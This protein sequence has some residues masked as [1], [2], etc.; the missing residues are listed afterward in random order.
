M[1]LLELI[2]R[3]VVCIKCPAMK[4]IVLLFIS[5][6]WNETLI[7]FLKNL[8]INFK[9]KINNTTDRTIVIH[10]PSQSR[11]AHFMHIRSV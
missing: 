4:Q 5:K 3:Q 8:I 2:R 7:F 10:E 11:S 1:N 6:N 9:F